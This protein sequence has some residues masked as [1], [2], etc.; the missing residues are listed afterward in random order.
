M[1]HQFSSEHVVASHLASL[2]SLRAV[3][4]SAPVRT[5]QKYCYDVKRSNLQYWF[6]ALIQESLTASLMQSFRSSSRQ[7]SKRSSRD[8]CFSFRALVWVVRSFTGD[9][10]LSGPAKNTQNQALPA[11]EPDLKWLKNNFTVIFFIIFYIVYIKCCYQFSQC[12]TTDVQTFILIP[13]IT[14]SL[15]TILKLYCTFPS[16]SYAVI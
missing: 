7:I 5:K 8:W 12:C 10:G 15:C 6:K 13:R 3:H 4:L 9:V 2:D 11:S 16:A 1:K 14:R